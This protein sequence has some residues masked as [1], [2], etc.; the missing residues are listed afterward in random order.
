MQLLFLGS[1]SAFT[2]GEDN[3]H[4]NILVTK[5]D[6]AGGHKRLL[7]DC[8]SDIRFALYDA[9]IVPCEIS[10]IYISHLH[11]DHVGGL[12]FIGFNTLFNPNC[13]RPNL[14]GSHE[15]LEDLWERSLSGGMWAI[16]GQT[17][18]LETFFQ[19]HAL[20]SDR[21]FIWED[22]RFELVSVPHVNSGTGLMPTYGLLFR[23]G[24]TTIF[25]TTDTQFAPDLLF[26]YY[27]Q[28][29]LIFHDCET[30]SIPTT[31]HSHYNQLLTIPEEIRGKMW[32][33]GYQPGPKPNPQQDGFL[34]FVKR[35]Q[36]FEFPPP[37]IQSWPINPYTGLLQASKR[38]ISQPR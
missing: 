13:I 6:E 37:L 8:G 31:V 10:D 19:V 11:S 34:G 7:L 33:C 20:D 12:E 29:D 30:G 3:Y 36:V 25:Y 5:T 16:E 23:I 32:L 24:Q 21:Y 38:V 9:G 27:Q 15:V 1:G 22:I 4:C 26:P 18:T 17:T 28:S 2:V 14:Y 35:G